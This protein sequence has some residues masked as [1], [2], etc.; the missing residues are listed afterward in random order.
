[1]KSEKCKWK[2]KEVEFL[3]IFRDSN[4]T[5]GDKNGEG[6]SKRSFGMADIKI[7]QRCAEILGASKLLLLVYRRVCN[8]GKAITR[9]SKKR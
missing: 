2:V 4:R 1:M 9:L 5:R 8:S 3:G 7:H 6:E